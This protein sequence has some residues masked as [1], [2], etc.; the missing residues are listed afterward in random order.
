MASHIELSN[1]NQISEK[2]RSE[3]DVTYRVNAF[4]QVVLGKV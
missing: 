3:N 4:V 2:F 1:D